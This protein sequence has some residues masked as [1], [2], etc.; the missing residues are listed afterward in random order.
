MRGI[1]ICVGLIFVDLAGKRCSFRR[2]H[3]GE[4]LLRGK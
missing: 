3:G 1:P 4:G 2:R